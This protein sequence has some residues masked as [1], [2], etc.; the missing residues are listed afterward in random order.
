MWVRH[1][2]K[3]DKFRSYLHQC[4]RRV[5]K[6]LG[7]CL[8]AQKLGL[9][10]RK[11]WEVEVEAYLGSAAESLLYVSVAQTDVFAGHFQLP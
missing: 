7:G 6:A 8:H 10:Q 11:E 4:E 1:F 2:Y 3:H 5:I 9:A